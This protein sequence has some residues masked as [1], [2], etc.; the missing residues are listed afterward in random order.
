MLAFDEFKKKFSALSRLYSEDELKLVYR[1]IGILAE[2]IARIAF[3][4]AGLRSHQEGFDNVE[5]DKV[6]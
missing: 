1:D 6:S 5:S 3:E 4:R 2:I